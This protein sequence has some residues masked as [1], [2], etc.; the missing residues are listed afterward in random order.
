MMARKADEDEM[1]YNN[2]IINSMKKSSA[3]AV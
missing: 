2:D 1:F 3:Y